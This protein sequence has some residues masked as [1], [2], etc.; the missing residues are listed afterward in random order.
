MALKIPIDATVRIF[1]CAEASL[2]LEA[3]QHKRESKIYSR[4][5]IAASVSL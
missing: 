2:S 5:L 1:H 3:E 4:Q